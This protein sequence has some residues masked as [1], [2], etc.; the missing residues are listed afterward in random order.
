[1]TKQLPTN[2][3]AMPADA[4]YRLLKEK[5]NQLLE[6]AV[7]QDDLIRAGL[8]HRDGNQLTVG[9]AIRGLER[10]ILGVAG[11][12]DASSQGMRLL[13]STINQID[14]K[15]V[16][17]TQDTLAMRTKL[18]LVGKQQGLIQSRLDADS[19]ILKQTTSRIEAGEKSVKVLSK[20]ATT[21]MSN[22]AIGQGMLDWTSGTVIATSKAH[23][24]LSSWVEANR[25]F[26]ESGA[27]KVV[28]LQ[29]S[30]NILPHVYLQPEPPTVPVVGTSFKVGDMWI[31]SDNG[32][33]VH[34]WDGTV[35]GAAVDLLGATV[36]AQPE[37]PA[38]GGLNV[39]DL[40]FDTDNG[41]RMHRWNGTDWIDV[42][43]PRIAA[44]AAATTA[45]TAR[46]KVT[47]D[48]VET[49]SENLTTLS[50]EV[51]HGTT[52]LAATKQIADS[53]KQRVNDTGNGL[54][55]EQVAEESRQTKLTV[56]HGTTGLAA[57][58]TIADTV[59]NRITDT[60]NGLSIEQVAEE[61]RQTKLTVNHGTTGLAA[62]RQVADSVKQRVDNTGGGLTIE[63]VATQSSQTALA[64][65]H[66]TTGLAATRQVADSVKQRI[67]NTGRGLTIEQVAEQSYQTN[68]AVT[69]AATGLN[70][71]VST[72]TFTLLQNRVNN[73][74]QNNWSI[75]QLAQ[76]YNASKLAI[77]NASTGLSALNQITTAT[78]QELT[79]LKNANPNLMKNGGFESDLAGWGGWSGRAYPFFGW[80]AYLTA[81]TKAA[82]YDVEIPTIAPFTVAVNIWVDNGVG[83]ARFNVEFYNAAWGGL[84]SLASDAATTTANGRRI[85][86]SFTPPANTK[87]VR[88]VPH[89][90]GTTGTC[91]FYK[92]KMEV[93][94][95]PT[96][97]DMGAQVINNMESVRTLKGQIDDP[98]LGLNAKA[99][100]SSLDAVKIRLDNT[101]NGRSFETMVQQFNTTKAAVE[102]AATGVGA[103][104]NSLVGVKSNI[105]ILKN[106]FEPVM[107][108]AFSA[109]IQGWTAEYAHFEQWPAH[110]G[111]GAVVLVAT[112]TDPNMT[113]PAF[114]H[115]GSRGAVVRAF[116]RYRDGAQN[117]VDRMLYW[118]TESR[119]YFSGGANHNASNVKPF[120]DPD[121]EWHIVE[122]DL[123]QN[124]D[125]VTG[126]VTRLRIDLTRVVGGRVDVAW[127]SIGSRSAGGASQSLR[128]Q[129]ESINTIR[130]ELD[131][132][133]T[134]LNAKAAVTTVNS[135][136][137]RLQT[138]EKNGNGTNRLVNANM[139]MDLDNYVVGELWKDHAAWTNPQQNLAAP[140]WLPDG[141]F[142]LGLAPTGFPSPTAVPSLGSYKDIRICRGSGGARN[143]VVGN[144]RYIFSV[145]AAAHRCIAKGYAFAY[146]IN[147]V[148]CG[149]PYMLPNATSGGGRYLRDWSRIHVV[150]DLPPEAVTV[151]CVLRAEANGVGDNPYAWFCRPM[152]E[153]CATNTQTLPS[154]WNEGGGE[155]GQTLQGAVSSITNLNLAVGGVNGAVTQS[156]SINYRLG[157]L[158]AQWSVRL[159]AGTGRITGIKA[160]NDGERDGIEFQT[161][162]FRVRNQ[163]GESTMYLDAAGNLN[164]RGLVRESFIESS[165]LS[166]G[167]S[168][169]ATGGGRLAPFSIDDGRFYVSP[170]G[171]T[172]VDLTCDGF[173][174]PNYG[175][176]YHHK[177]FARQKMDVWFDVFVGGNSNSSTSGTETCILEVQYDGGGWTEITRVSGFRTSFKGSFPMLVR[178]T[179]LDS[180]GTV[181]FR[182][183]TIENM[184]ESLKLKITVNNM[185]ESGNAAGSNSGGIGAPS[186]GGTPPPPN[187]GGGVGGGGDIPL[188][189]IEP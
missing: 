43:D 119:N 80:C 33:Q 91:Y 24:A 151:D 60:G 66:G 187:G 28:E 153:E 21:L 122:W 185:N 97:Y 114:K 81:G 142:T 25:E 36:Y 95:K 117:D 106:D 3:N 70:A 152:L 158:Q 124:P 99:S 79:Y 155:F 26:I 140:D 163:A 77:E 49:V 44:N 94:D 41:M 188:N 17:Q 16:A 115:T 88:I 37:P 168:R 113:S 71:K 19:Q 102:D 75:E 134:G 105:S 52:G 121:G 62:T 132:P 38:A 73:V 51:R 29:G 55:I 128:N 92:F 67:E 54:S 65:N 149:G 179:T 123:S 4:E 98:T 174:S 61:S 46:V 175:S 170:E 154:P 20:D 133:T 172:S 34:V 90:S 48:T 14:G 18:A 110:Q 144:R 160:Y 8:L 30:V 138:E 42:S 164:I 159:D 9:T 10:K 63:Q 22:V 72:N 1:M 86:L 76:N 135:I 74:G 150:M 39:G 157:Q 57:V 182:A 171:R 47:E 59:R 2:T 11:T 147:G 129:I 6:S 7:T 180:W 167:S 162:N 118:A 82:W 108:W 125:W 186:G 183:R 184:T 131:N 68:L 87:Y 12:V 101:G 178:Y 145:H 103:L 56:N 146:N 176:G 116:V 166:L 137:L 136:D 13:E 111:Y 120:G 53:V 104:N 161:N 130:G 173:V 143:P 112:S 5:V 96:P 189:P 93:G 107:G 181:N 50:G 27:T 32:N 35:W 169:I 78:N 148:I 58:K 31:D 45:L 89:V 141:C 126:V 64:V 84:G 177:R 15:L 165:A 156:S 40:W 85:S 100:T 83:T 139:R 109:G 69:D 127:V 23:E